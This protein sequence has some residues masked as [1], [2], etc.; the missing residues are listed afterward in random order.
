VAKPSSFIEPMSPP[1]PLTHKT[2]TLSPVSGSTSSSL[3]EVLP[4]PK[5][6]TVRSEP[7]RFE[8]YSSSSAGDLLAASASDQRLAGTTNG[9][10]V[11]ALV[12]G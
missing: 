8:R 6:V 4:P 10:A 11:R 2:L 7:R 3:A 12:T 1:D 5:L 9:S